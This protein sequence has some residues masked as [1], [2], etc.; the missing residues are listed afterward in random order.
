MKQELALD[1]IKRQKELGT[2]FHYVGA[3]SL[4]GNSYHFQQEID[5]LELLFVLDIHS[6]RY[7]NTEPPVIAVPDKT[8]AAGR[9]PVVRKPLAIPLK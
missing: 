4:Y 2:W 5:K 6:D 7:L 9:T 3:D 8:A 1:I